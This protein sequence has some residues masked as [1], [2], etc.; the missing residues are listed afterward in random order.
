MQDQQSELLTRVGPGTAMGALLRRFWIPALL[1]EEVAT[2]DCPPLRLRLLGEDLVA[3]RDTEGRVGILEA[4]CPHR[5]AGLFFG[6]NEECGLRCVYHGWKFDV[7]GRCV[8]MPSEP[9]E[10]QH[11]KEN[12]K[13]LAYPTAVRGGV[14]WVY[15]GPA[16]RMPPPPEFEWSRL[17]ARRRTATKRLQSCNW[18]QAVEG[19]IDSAHISFVHRNLKDAHAKGGAV[20]HARF[21]A[22]DRHPK[23][24]V[25]ATDYGLLIG[26]KRQAEGETRDYWRITQYLLPFYSMIPPVLNDA[27][28]TYT[29]L[30]GHAWVPIDDENTWTWS[31][32]CDP[33]KDFTDEELERYGGRN[34]MWGP[35]DE[36][37]HPLLNLAN[38]YLID[39]QLQRTTSFTGIK[40]I[41]N[42]D[43]AVQESM[44]A[45]VDRSRE[46][47]GHS[48]AAII[49][50]RKRML[51][52]V[53]E[54]QSGVEPKAAAHAEWYN[55]RPLSILLE[56]GADF[57]QGA[58]ALLQG[59][60]L[61]S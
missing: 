40:G 58:G 11:L 48:D 49:A 50:F 17:P 18:A 59:A 47:L 39:R 32:G 24:T 52:L 16:E 38:D 15:M 13:A 41:P 42:Q 61:Q 4:N 7:N 35:V 60:P 53:Q 9:P 21:A 5:R 28:Y 12:V 57:E 56:K 19:G 27:T 6:R 20:N 14:V 54:L 45:I 46:H 8:D 51:K 25:R 43:A 34:G 26:A 22:K 29:P 30:L 31:F 3:F 2:P 23:F 55:V 44:G 10:R 36:R 1:E 37:Y 33:D